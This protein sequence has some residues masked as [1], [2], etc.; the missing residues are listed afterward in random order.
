M[1]K[2]NPETPVD[3][4][5]FHPVTDVVPTSKTK[6]AYG[7]AYVKKTKKKQPKRKKK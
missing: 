5:S 6:A 2:I 3:P 4:S 7:E 1:N